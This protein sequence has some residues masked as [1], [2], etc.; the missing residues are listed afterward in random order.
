MK[1][2]QG[3]TCITCFFQLNTQGAEESYSTVILVKYTVLMHH[4]L[5]LFKVPYRVCDLSACHVIVLHV[6]CNFRVVDASESKAFQAKHT[7]PRV[8][9]D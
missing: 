5:I 1:C 9:N 3:M 7:V 8:K 2:V 4:H 6:W